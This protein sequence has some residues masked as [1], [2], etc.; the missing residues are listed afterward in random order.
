MQSRSL[1]YSRLEGALRDDTKTRCVA[2]WFGPRQMQ[3][4]PVMF[5]LCCGPQ[6]KLRG[7]Q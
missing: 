4:L 7:D 2:D 1:L 6:F 3:V 5:Y